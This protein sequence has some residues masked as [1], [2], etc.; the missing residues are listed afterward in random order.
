[1]IIMMNRSTPD[2]F[3]INP[4]LELEQL[5]FCQNSVKS[6]QA[7]ASNLS[8]LQLGD[9]SRAL[10][11]ALTEI[12]SLICEE[13]L[14]FDLV[15]AIHATLETILESL[16]KN[17][18][19][20]TLIISDRNEHIIELA[21]LL[22]IEF[23]KVYLK[24]VQ[25]AD[26]QLNHERFSLF[27]F[28]FKKNLQTARTLATYYALQQLSRLLLQQKLLYGSTLPQQWLVTHRLAHLAIENNYHLLNINQIQGTHYAIENVL[29]VYAQI[30]L[31]Q[32]FNTHQ[33][34]PAEIQGLFSCSEHWVKLV[35]ISTTQN[36]TSR[37]MV[38]CQQDDSPMYC[39]THA[40]SL[41]PYLFIS[42]QRLL[43]HL[44]KHQNSRKNH[45]ASSSERLYLTPAL[46]FHLHQV[47]TQNTER[48]HERYTYNARIRICFGLNVAHFYL[49]NGK[50]FA[51]TLQ[52]DANYQVQNEAHIIRSLTQKNVNLQQNKALD[53]EL[54]RVFSVHILD[55]SV[56]GYRI[57]WTGEAPK[58]LKTGEFILVQ[59][60]I[61]SPW[62]AG[63]VR[64]IKQVD[65]SDQKG[66]DVGIEILA[67]EIVPCAIYLKTSQS[68]ANYHP[69]LFMQNHEL[70]RTVTTLILPGIHVLKDKQ[71]IQLRVG[72]EDIKVFLKE[73]PLL[74]TQSFMQFEFE[75]ANEQQ[76]PVLDQFIQQRLNETKS[77]DLWGSLK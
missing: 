18:G 63:L 11:H 34:R 50:N 39:D 38:N 72:T 2:L 13:T 5:S 59:E 65:L 46:L 74:I 1:M 43:E 4:T 33:I 48:R 8:M 37:Y 70:D 66:L 51:D 30:L 58:N 57:Q 7:W 17:F 64:W 55:I 28:R 21:L 47:L 14:R 24:I 23:I 71:T 15:Q 73:K 56:N 32:I 16:E 12:S 69:A 53:R 36:L 54:R 44:N 45:R 35:D 52:L 9:S 75:L 6:I 25:N 31:L 42:T 26:D 67:Q 22:R 40:D 3:Q 27:A 10:F 62:R 60:N 49:S 29:Q 68:H 20:Q 19:T 76:Q 41:D 61:Q 77:Y